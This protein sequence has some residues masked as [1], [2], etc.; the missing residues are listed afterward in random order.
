MAQAAQRKPE[1]E[2]IAGASHPQSPQIQAFFL[3][4]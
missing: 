1:F 2:V 4:G 3:F